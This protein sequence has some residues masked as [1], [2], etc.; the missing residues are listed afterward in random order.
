MTE[1]NTS[2]E[3]GGEQPPKTPKRRSRVWLIG[4][5]IALVGLGAF[6]AGHIAKHANAGFGH[7]FKHGL[8]PIHH[9]IGDGGYHHKAH[10]GGRWFGRGPMTE[11]RAQRRATRMARHLAAAVDA[12]PEQTDA[13]KGIASALVKDLFPLRQ[14]MKAS[15]QKAADILTSGAVDRAEL[16]KLRASQMTKA[17]EATKRIVTALADAAETMTE[18]QR[19]ELRE[20]IENFREMRSWWRG[21]DDSRQ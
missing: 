12:T 14:D 6:G 8:G 17:D 9:V 11:E 18:S 13:F 20:R 21:A 4:G 5:A 16:E 19:T 1:T 15:R 10:F 3:P 2:N 7:G